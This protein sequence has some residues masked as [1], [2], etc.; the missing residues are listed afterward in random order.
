LRAPGTSQLPNP[1]AALYS[2]L[3]NVNSLLDGFAASILYQ[4]IGGW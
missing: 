4:E 2:T 1:A 3:E